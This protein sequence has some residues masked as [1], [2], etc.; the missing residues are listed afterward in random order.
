[1][2]KLF[3][4]TLGILSRPR[5]LPLAR[6]SLLRSYTSLVKYV[7]SGICGGKTSM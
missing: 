2:G 1:V 7:C 6:Y 3:N 4:I 5:A